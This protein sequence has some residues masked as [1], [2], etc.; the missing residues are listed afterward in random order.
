MNKLAK[1]RIFIISILSL[2]AYVA[3]LSLQH[4]ASSKSLS[5]VFHA[6]FSTNE[7]LHSVVIY[8]LRLPRFLF[9]CLAGIGLAVSGASLQGLFRNPLTEP[10][11]IGVSSGAACF[12]AFVIVLSPLLPLW[13]VEDLGDLTLSIFAFLGSAITTIV[14]YFL[15]DYRNNPS[16]ST[17][18]LTGIAVTAFFFGVVGFLTYLADDQ[19]LRSLTFW[20]LGS[21]AGATWKLVAIV[22]VPIAISAIAIYRLSSSLDA[23]SL[24]ESNAEH[25]GVDVVRLS[26]K[27]IIYS[28]LS[29]GAITA[30][31]G[32]ISFVGIIVPHVARLMFGPNHRFLIIASI[33]LGALFMAATDLLSR[34]LFLPSELPIN[35]IT[36]I[37]GAP[38]FIFLLIKSKKGKLAYV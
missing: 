6:L 35:I 3:V 7:D 22:S 28:A 2:L 25:L 30:F 27:V 38:L 18:L 34:T 14:V 12:A 11:I 16:I 26:W 13:L 33:L 1:K 9:A 15:S 21:L 36:S 32:I 10:S 20:N 8:N 37:A 17:L 23:L 5:E 4:G 24:G 31:C 29:V 19:Q